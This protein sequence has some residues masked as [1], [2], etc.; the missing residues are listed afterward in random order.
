MERAVKSDATTG[1]V[2]HAT[3]RRAIS[4]LWFAVSD[5]SWQ[6][7]VFMVCGAFSSVM[8]R[9]LTQVSMVPSSAV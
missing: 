3:T 5:S 1:K 8:R 9:W 7:A 6:M 4:S 2:P